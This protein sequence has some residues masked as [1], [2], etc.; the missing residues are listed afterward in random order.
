MTKRYGMDSPEVR[1][2]RER[3]EQR[4]AAEYQ[5]LLMPE[6]GTPAWEKGL[7]LSTPFLD[8]IPGS[9]TAMKGLLLGGKGLLGSVPIL[10][11]MAKKPFGDGKNVIPI[12]V[13]KSIREG[14][15]LH[16]TADL[17]L[18]KAKRMQATEDPLER[19]YIANEEEPPRFRAFFDHMLESAR[20]SKNPELVD[21]AAKKDWNLYRRIKQQFH[22][23]EAF[24]V[25][26]WSRGTQY[27]GKGNR[28]NDLGI[29]LPEW[30]DLTFNVPDHIVNRIYIKLINDPTIN[31]VKVTKTTWK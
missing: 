25:H 24:R 6:P 26:V 8:L 29:Q 14:K 2:R 3:E 16:E 11:G 1:A 4:R 18:A 15:K 10:A 9:G 20:Q 31:P 23:R 19:W 22:D 12:N 27:D 17:E 13:G 5:R 21:A 30:L 28:F 7:G